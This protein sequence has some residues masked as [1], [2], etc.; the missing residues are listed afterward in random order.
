MAFVENPPGDTQKRAYYLRI[1]ESAYD[2]YDSTAE[3]GLLAILPWVHVERVMGIDE[4]LRNHRDFIVYENQTTPF[5]LLLPEL[6]RRGVSLRLLS[7]DVL[8]A[9]V[10]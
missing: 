6:L 7:R 3:R 4:F 2:A 1:P 10:P 5:D 8:Q 9:N